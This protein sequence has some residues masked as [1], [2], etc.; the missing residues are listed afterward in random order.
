MDETPR[1]PPLPPA[2]PPER[3]R[4][5]SESEMAGD[6]QTLRTFYL[7][8]AIVNGIAAIGWALTAVIVGVTT[9]GFGCII[10][11]IPIFAG[12]ALYM[13]VES[14]RRI[15]RGLGAGDSSFLLSTAILDIVAGICGSVVPIVFGVLECV[16]LYRPAIQT[17]F[18]GPAGQPGDQ[19]PP[20]P[21]DH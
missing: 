20:P 4:G 8:S 13:D 14:I 17:A 1:N 5:I 19:S 7:V 21:A 18:Y 16:W 9:C 2:P 3:P 11:V 12:V 10:V 15:D 6:L